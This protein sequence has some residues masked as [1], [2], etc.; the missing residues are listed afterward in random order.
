[1]ANN[2][3]GQQTS[4]GTNV[5]EVRQQNSQAAQGQ[6]QFGSEFASETD[7]QHVKQANRQAE[8]NKQQNS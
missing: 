2:K 6:G 1:M 3:F 4:T 8:A 7:V 5:Q